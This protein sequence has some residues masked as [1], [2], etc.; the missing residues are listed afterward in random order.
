MAPSM[1]RPEPI[2]GRFSLILLALAACSGGSKS[3]PVGDATVPPELLACRARVDSPH[4]F[5]E[6]TL[7]SVQNLGATRIADKAGR[8]RHARVHPDSNTVVFARERTNGD[9]DSRELFTATIDGTRGELRLTQNAALDDEPCWSPSG[10]MI[11]FASERAGGRSLWLC[12]TDGGNPRIF[13]DPPVGTSEGEPDWCRATDRIVLSRRDAGGRN[14]LWLV[15]GDGTGIA[16]LTDGGIAIGSDS[17]DHHPA[18]SPDGSKV[19]FAR[20]FTSGLASLCVIEIATGIVTTRYQPAGEADLPRWTPTGDRLLFGLAEPT[21]GRTTLRLASIPTTTGDPVLVWPDERWRLEGIDV[22]PT[23]ASAPA[24]A[25]PRGL[26]ITEA[27]VQ[28]A[29]GTAQNSSRTQLASVDGN[30][31]RVLTEN[32]GDHE[33]AGINCRFDLPVLRAEDMLELHIRAVARVGRI[34]GDTALRM[35]IYNSADERFDTVVELSPTDTAARTMTF[36]TSSLRHL[37]RERQLRVTVV[38]EIAPGARSE[39]LVDLVE[40]ILIARQPPP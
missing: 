11:L 2:P 5:A 3:S 39:L 9:P 19:A 22:L 28:I 35:S 25:A 33:V 37:T 14:T 13:Q 18:F 7:R 31:F 10:S 4:S 29:A 21:N 30:E 16:P 36:S 24:A 32:N 6:I 38:G 17:G 15:Q 8:E 40:V 26:D 1:P 23:L 20:R 34:G 12:N 27:Q